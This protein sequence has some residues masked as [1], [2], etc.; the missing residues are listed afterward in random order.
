MDA[1]FPKFVRSPA[2]NDLQEQFCSLALA[3]ALRMTECL[4][5][6]DQIGFR[7]YTRFFGWFQ[8]MAKSEFFWSG[9]LEC[10]IE[11]SI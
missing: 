11:C 6:S 5:G 10:V 3:R 9:F 8:I 4:V 2:H 7:H 1:H